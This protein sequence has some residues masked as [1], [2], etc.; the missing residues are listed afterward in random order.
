MGNFFPRILLV[1][2]F[3]VTSK[4]SANDDW[5]NSNFWWENAH[6][7]QIYP[8]SFSDSDGDG[9]GDLNGITSRLPYL[10]EIGVTG[11]WMS[12][13]FES[14]MKDFGYDIS[15]FGKIGKFDPLLLTIL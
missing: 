7:Y 6:F 11:A 15:D 5:H 1:T 8:R 12:P 2:L 14:P 13:I 4:V 10:K 9:V 3:L